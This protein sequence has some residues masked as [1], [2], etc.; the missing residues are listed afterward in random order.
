[1]KRRNKPR[2]S[3]CIAVMALFMFGIS[4]VFSV[5]CAGRGAWS[6]LGSGIGAISALSMAPDGTMYVAG[7]NSGSAR[8][9]IAKWDGAVW[10]NIESGIFSFL[11]TLIVAPDGTLYAAGGFEKIGETTCFVAGWN[12]K[13]WSILGNTNHYVLSLMIGPDGA[14]YAGGYF[15]EAGG[16]VASCIARWNGHNWSALGSGAFSMVGGP[17]I[18]FDMA[19]GP[20]GTLYVGG[21]FKKAGGSNA[22]FVA[23]W[24]G[25]SWSGLGP[26]LNQIVYSLAFAPDGTL[27]AAGDFTFAGEVSVNSV[28]KWNGSAWAPLGVGVKQRGVYDL[29]TAP[30]GTLYAAGSYI[31]AGQ[32][33]DNRIASWNGSIWAPLGQGIDMRHGVSDLLAGPDGTLYVAGDFTEAGGVSANG[34]ARWSPTAGAPDITPSLFLLL[35]D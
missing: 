4:G 28:A 2:Y 12:G 25:N 16:V 8:G 22:A 10:S 23:K 14:L 19:F 31:S 11:M 1:M 24:D 21:Q 33:G 34:I 13:E 18:V 20:D 3:M 26:G 17:P 32:A 9:K 6:S 15:S 29:A 5:A 30:D 35:T 7:S 27:Y